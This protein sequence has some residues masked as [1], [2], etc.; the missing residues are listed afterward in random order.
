MPLLSCNLIRGVAKAAE[1]HD[2]QP[3]HLSFEGALQTMTAFQDVMRYAPPS[4][5]R[6]LV[7]AMLES[8][9]KPRGRRP[10]RSDGA[11]SEQTSAEAAT[12]SQ[13]VAS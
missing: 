6:R 1:A 11:T 7:E 12:L 3:R 4:D 10:L 9:F 8:D 2:N 5:R 13:R